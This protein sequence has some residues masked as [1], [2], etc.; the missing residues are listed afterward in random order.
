MNAYKV[1]NSQTSHII[2]FTLAIIPCITKLLHA[3][4]EVLI[5]P[6]PHRV[7]WWKHTCK[8]VV[9]FVKN[10]SW[11]AVHSLTKTLTLLQKQH[12]N[13]FKSP[14]SNAYTAVY[15]MAIRGGAA[16]LPHFFSRSDLWTMH[17]GALYVSIH[18]RYTVMSMIDVCFARVR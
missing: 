13:A 11:K 16:K 4:T 15:S 3:K 5:V 17:R 6:F 9:N 10:F 18:A 2:Q 1:H 12:L 7:T 8:T 14:A